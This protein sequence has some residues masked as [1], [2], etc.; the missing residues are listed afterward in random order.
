MTNILKMSNAGGFKTLT[1]YPDMLAGNTT[2]NPWEPAGAYESIAAAT[3]PSGGAANI[4]F[5]SI[6]QNYSHL[7]IRFIARTGSS[8]SMFYRFN[9]DSGSNYSGRHRLTGDGST[10]AAS[11]S[12]SQAQ[13]YTFGTSGLPTATSTFGVGVADIL[14]Y[15]NTNKYKTLRQL[16]GWDANGSGVVEFVSGAWM[17]TNAITEINIGLDSGSFV[18]NS[19]FALYGIKG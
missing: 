4:T 10:A 7:Q 1:R 9:N 16:D 3:V 6:P 14:D 5:N 15:A 11:G 12:S 18:Q 13:I 19:S 8:S 2:W 17:N